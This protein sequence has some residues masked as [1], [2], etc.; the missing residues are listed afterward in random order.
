MSGVYVDRY[1]CI[2]QEG[3]AAHQRMDALEVGLR[4]LAQEFFSDRPKEVGIRWTRLEEGWAWTAGEP[5][6]ASRR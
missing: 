2:I 4:K 1:A 3:Q 5:L 6:T